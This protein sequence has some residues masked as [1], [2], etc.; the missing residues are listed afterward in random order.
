[1]MMG[2]FYQ[3]TLGKIR[4]IDNNQCDEKVQMSFKWK[5]WL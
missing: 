5:F 2:D 4:K 1:M 3:A